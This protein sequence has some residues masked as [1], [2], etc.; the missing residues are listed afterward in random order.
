VTTS[1]TPVI[2]AQAGRVV[3]T[4][5]RT[6]D[7]SG[8]STTLPALLA[9]IQFQPVAAGTSQISM[10]GVLMNAAGQPITVQMVPANVVVK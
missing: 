3:I 4:M 9:A 1:F 8:V 6:G 7:Q 2:D 10:T 5:A